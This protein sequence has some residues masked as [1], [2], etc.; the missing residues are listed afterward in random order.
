MTRKKILILHG[1]PY[2]YEMIPSV[3]EQFK[4]YE[5]DLFV[6][7]IKSDL[8]PWITSFYVKLNVPFRLL[9]TVSDKNYDLCCLPTDDDKKMHEFYNKNLVGI[10]VY[11]INHLKGSNRNEVD[12]SYKYFIDIHGVQEVNG[13]QHF[14][15][16]SLLHIPKKMST[17]SKETISVATIG[18]IIIRE[19]NFIQELRSK[20][21]N[22]NQIDF[23]IINRNITVSLLSEGYKH[24]N[25]HFFLKCDAQTMFHILERCHYVYYFSPSGYL[26]NSSGC[27]GLSYSFLCRLICDKR[28][29]IQL[30]TETPLFVEGKDIIELK[31]LDEEQIIEIEKERTKFISRTSNHIKKLLS[32]I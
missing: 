17:L 22:F 4:D 24:D 18:D 19:K 25:I 12:D 29:Q 7:P 6:E 11:I 28:R 15:G 8:I 13:P 31:P 26:T 3:L 9:K 32:D 27:F 16:S 20:F 10:P 23:F 1:V 5:I 30:E 2:H 14:C 21:T